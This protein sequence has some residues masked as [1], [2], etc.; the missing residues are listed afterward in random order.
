VYHRD[1]DG[2][3]R[4]TPADAPAIAAIYNWYVEN[5]VITFEVDPVSDAE[6]A[7]R[8]ASTL[9]KYEWLVHARG[10]EILGYAYAARFRER[11]A[12]RFI[13]ESTIYLRNGLQGQGLGKPLYRETIARTFALGY[14]SLVGGI[15]LPNEASVR[16][17][18]SLGFEKVGHLHRVGWKHERWID[19]GSW[20]LSK[21]PS[22]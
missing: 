20:Q 8:I 18:E 16:L 7:Q 1:V 5:T 3:R 11:A 15:A 6:M 10:S 14:T 19:V 22:A 2:I 4:A 21:P 9:V 13:T 17:H 12:Y